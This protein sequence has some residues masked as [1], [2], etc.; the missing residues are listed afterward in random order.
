[1][2]LRKFKNFE[3][4]GIQGTCV[5]VVEKDWVGHLLIYHAVKYSAGSQRSL[6]AA[7]IR[8]VDAYLY[9]DKPPKKQKQGTRKND[10]GFNWHGLPGSLNPPQ[11]KGPVG[12]PSKKES[13]LETA[14]KNNSK[15]GKP[16]VSLLPMDV[17]TEFLVPAYEEG[18]L[19][20]DRES[21]RKGFQTSVL[22]DAAQRHMT[23]F[24]Y[25]REDWDPDAVKLGVKK[26]HLAG[27]IFSLL[28]ILW[29]LKTRPELD[30]RSKNLVEEK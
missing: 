27:A 20:Y 4:R 2:A 30:D 9:V 26:H 25:L 5:Q 16:R 8:A 18:C 6:R 29:S 10:D 23:D 7:F 28:S 21:W 17:L 24:F 3:Y 11:K 12:E 22:I 1:M 13:V 14:P 19:K 15:E